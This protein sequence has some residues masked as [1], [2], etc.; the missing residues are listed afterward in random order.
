MKYEKKVER[1]LEIVKM[2]HEGKSMSE[3]AE[4]FGISPSSVHDVCVRHGVAGVMSDRKGTPSPINQYTNGT[5]DRE[6][7]A[8]RY[9]NERTPNFEYAGNFTGLDGYVDLKCKTCGT[10]TRKSFVTVKHGTA[11]CL[12]C[13][14]RKTQEKQEAKRADREKQ[15]QAEREAREHDRW[16][17]MQYVQTTICKCKQ[18][19]DYFISYSN[20]KVYC[21][22]ACAKKMDNSIGSDKR[23]KKLKHA[24]VD[25]DI[26]LER[27][28]KRDKGKCY[29]CGQICDWNDCTVRDNGVFIA[30]DNYPS[31]D[32]V[33]PLSKGGKHSWKNIKLA[34]RRCNSLKSDKIIPA[35]P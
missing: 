32:H 4:H 11:V 26:T 10:I 9:I 31:I 24:M 22:D 8:I 1:N 35:T 28:Y 5:F 17:H 15:K 30:N 19:G 14:K 20:R 13:A 16:L 6:A 27:L 33:K 34:C 7:N 18:C 29:I 25:K 21:S 12:E 3:I 2:R 23:V